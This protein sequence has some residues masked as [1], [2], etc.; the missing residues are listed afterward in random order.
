MCDSKSKERRT[1]SPAEE[2][3]TAGA[4]CASATATWQR[5]RG[6]FQPN[7]SENWE[8][9]P[10]AVS[11][12]FSYFKLHV[13]RC[14]CYSAYFARAYGKSEIILLRKKRRNNTR[15]SHDNGIGNHVRMLRAGGFG[16]DKRI[17]ACATMRGTKMP[18]ALALSIRTRVLNRG[19][20]EGVFAYKQLMFK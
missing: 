3:D 16:Q 17:L 7:T 12:W 15:A 1:Q 13:H 5:K 20:K 2:K 14:R 10:L 11:V 6:Y 19:L 8:Y 18:K 9:P 4:S